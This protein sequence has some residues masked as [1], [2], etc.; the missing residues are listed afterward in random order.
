LFKNLSQDLLKNFLNKIFPPKKR[1]QFYL[2]ISLIL[3]LILGIPVVNFYFKKTEVQPSFGGTFRE[4][5]I[6][7][8]RF[9]NPLYISDNDVDRDLVELLFSG[10]MKYNEN[11]EVVKD[12]ADD[13]EIKEEG[14][15]YEIKLKENIFWHDGEPLTADDIVFTINLLQNPEYKSSLAIKWSGV[16]IEKLS[17]RII[18]FRLKKAYPGFLETLTEKIIPKH[19]FQDISPKNLP[20]ALSSEEHL[21]EYL[22]GS[23]PF[24][25]KQLVRN[26][27][28]GYIES[29]TLVSNQNYFVKKPFISQISFHFF[30]NKEDSLK[31]A[32]QGKI[33]G[34]LISDPS[35]L[36]TFSEKTFNSF[37]LSLPR[38]FAVFFNYKSKLL[39]S[40]EI[41][42]ALNYAVDKKE[43]LEKTVLGKGK[44][45]D[46]P[47][48]PDFYGF[49]PPSKIYQFDKKKAEEI[50]EEA[51][52]KYI[53]E[54]GI[55][56]KIISQKSTFSFTKTL[57]YGSNDDEVTQ[58]QKCLADPAVG[59]PEI[60]PSGKITGY[61][62]NETK[63]A[64]ILFQERYKED[65]LAPSGLEKGTGQ[66]K[67]ETREKLNQ[68]CFPQKEEILPLQFSLVTVDK[69]LMIEIS[70]L[71][72][73]SWKEIGANVEIKSEAISAMETD[74]IKPRNFEALLFGEVLN[75]MPD[76]FPF[77]HSSQ[78]ES[79]GL[80]LVS[81]ENKKTDNLLE[82]A[83]ATLDNSLRKEKLEEFQ[84]LLIE[85]A[86]CL[87]LLRPDLVYF[88]S[89]KVKGQTV[90]KI[91]E[92]SKRFVGIENWYVK[93]KRICK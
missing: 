83:R 65:I 60:Y 32:F 64:V 90:E 55:R 34:L 53:D 71:L 49:E 4:G 17:D 38:Y 58:L 5:V 44:I 40:K 75:S 85:D 18:Q 67:S 86:P 84:D 88:T 29:L 20:W 92:P 28:S 87:F 15:I 54:S 22:V 2:P 24:Q 46:S 8:P 39:T 43:I 35:D 93:T 16:S 26:N 77:W 9:I 6:G 41:R 14:Q 79:P 36:E 74:I 3:L 52:F 66:I 89:K 73:K 1:K 33:D 13:L 80:N 23:G 19:I 51:G 42:E 21:E 31:S 78:K 12:L 25:F 59:G 45:V 81:Y 11:G 30:A 48:L 37:E 10:L 68:L 50:L 72:Q 61:F 27:K 91:I 63:Q 82:E 57:Q 76:P 70:Q 62:G 47:I 56:K 7:Q 69:P